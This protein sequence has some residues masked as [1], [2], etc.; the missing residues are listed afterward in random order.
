MLLSGRLGTSAGVVHKKFFVIS[1]IGKTL[2][3]EDNRPP[4]LSWASLSSSIRHPATGT[5]A[6]SPRDLPDL[7]DISEP[8]IDHTMHSEFHGLCKAKEIS[9][10]R[11]VL[12]VFDGLP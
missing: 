3:H 12:R 2:T 10:T 6:K 9:Q 7:P 4:R 8:L 1:P 11:R 5:N